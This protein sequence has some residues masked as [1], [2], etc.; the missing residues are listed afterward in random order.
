MDL[1]YLNKYFFNFINTFTSI[2]I[3]YNKMIL[4][5]IPIYN[6]ILTDFIFIGKFYKILKLVI[7][8]FN[9]VI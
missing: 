7:I 6:T 5:N 1:D 2:F 9:Y 3:F 8:L 4:I